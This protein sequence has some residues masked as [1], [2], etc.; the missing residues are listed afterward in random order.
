MTVPI[1]VLASGRGSNLQ[2]IIDAIKSGYIKKA[3]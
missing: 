2:A 3:E 1:G